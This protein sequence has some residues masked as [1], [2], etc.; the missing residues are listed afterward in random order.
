MFKRYKSNTWSIKNGTFTNIFLKFIASSDS[1]L[2]PI[3][4]LSIRLSIPI[5]WIR[6]FIFILK[7]I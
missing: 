5:L 4:N 6:I 3:L 2:H 7:L 1:T